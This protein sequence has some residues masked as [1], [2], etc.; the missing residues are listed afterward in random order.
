MYTKLGNI[1]CTM[2]RR[3]CCVS[4][5]FRSVSQRR[6]FSNIYIFENPIPHAGLEQ[7]YQFALVPFPDS[8]NKDIVGELLKFSR[9]EFTPALT[10]E[11]EDT[12]SLYT[13]TEINKDNRKPN[14][15]SLARCEKKAEKK[16]KQYADSRTGLESEPTFIQYVQGNNGKKITGAFKGALR[17]AEWETR[18]ERFDIA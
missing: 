16:E 18:C 4:P 13:S 12:R 7:L 5:I 3:T 11:R 8:R 10:C 1:V 14:G 15:I 17:Y 2:G 9:I 6:W